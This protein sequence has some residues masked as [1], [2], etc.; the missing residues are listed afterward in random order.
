MLSWETAGA[1]QV[2]ID[3]IGSV[4]TSGSATVSPTSNTT[5]TITATNAFGTV[6][7]TVSIDVA[8][9]GTP[10]ILASWP[11]RRRSE[12]G[13]QSTLSWEVERRRHGEITDLGTVDE[14][15]TSTVTPTETKDY[16]L[17]ARNAQGEVTATV[18]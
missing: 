8:A 11:R 10:R 15:G 17:T 4:G 3:K 1:D 9:A 6:S 7:S 13:E 18:P 16:V 12:P 14:S 5:Y 2:T